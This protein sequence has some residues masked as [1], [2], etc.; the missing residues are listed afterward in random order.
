MGDIGTNDQLHSS[1]GL[2][3][4]TTGFI[5]STDDTRI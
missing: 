1:N 2:E 5:L 3:P 4:A